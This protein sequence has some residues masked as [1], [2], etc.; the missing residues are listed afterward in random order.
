VSIAKRD[1]WISTRPKIPQA[2]EKRG[3]LKE[4]VSVLLVDLRAGT[5]NEGFGKVDPTP[6]EIGLDLLDTALDLARL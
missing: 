4:T 6:P 1:Q 5:L 3:D 2:E